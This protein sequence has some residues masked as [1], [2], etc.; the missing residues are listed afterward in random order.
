MGDRSGSASPER[1]IG[2]DPLGIPNN[3]MP[4]I[5]K[6]AVGELDELSVFGNDYDTPD[7]T[8]I[9][10]YIHVMDLAAAHVKS[11]AWMSA[12][13]EAPLRFVSE[14]EGYGL[15]LPGE[16][17]PVGHRHQVQGL[18]QDIICHRRRLT[19]LW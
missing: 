2:E 1:D 6:V 11:L 3:L 16:E 14:D 12:Q 15:R 9:R 17:W 13:P 19:T 4:Y 7:G 8:C 18:G 5:T 10:D